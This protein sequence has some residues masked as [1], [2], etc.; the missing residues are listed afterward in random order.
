MS[1]QFRIVVFDQPGQPAMYGGGAVAEELVPERLGGWRW[2]VET[3]SGHHD[4]QSRRSGCLFDTRLKAFLDADRCRGEDP[5]LAD[6]PIID[7][8][9]DVELDNLNA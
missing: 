8:A 1:A 5:T 4:P 6:A 2:K 7:E 9:T 3:A